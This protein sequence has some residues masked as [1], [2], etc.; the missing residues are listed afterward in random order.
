MAEEGAA[1]QVEAALR[2]DPKMLEVIQ[3][4]QAS[5]LMAICGGE[6]E[7]P[8]VPEE[9]RSGLLMLSVLGST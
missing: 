1:K 8:E 6:E 4:T 5:M 3:N 9:S 2:W 7:S